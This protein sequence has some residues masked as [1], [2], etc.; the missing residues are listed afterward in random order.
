MQMWQQPVKTL[1]VKALESSKLT[2]G[3]L[4]FTDQSINQ[5]LALLSSKDGKLATLDLS[6]ASDRVHKDP[7][8]RMLNVNPSLRD[9]V[10]ITRS[11]RAAVSKSEFVD[12]NKFASMG[13]ALCFPIESLY[14]YILCICARL[15]HKHLQPSIETIYKVTR[16]IYVYG[17]DIIV[18]SNEVDSII[19]WL[20][21][22]GNKVGLAKSFW[23]GRFRE[24]CGCDAYDGVDITPIYIRQPLHGKWKSNHIAS[25]V[26]T[27]NLF[28]KKGL[29]S[30]ANLLRQMV[31]REVGRLPY[32]SEHSE[33]LGWTFCDEQVKTRYN[34]G[35][36]RLE[37]RTLVPKASKKSDALR[38]YS[39]L[40]KCLLKL[41][42]RLESVGR[43]GE[44]SPIPD[45]TSERSSFDDAM[46]DDKEHL[47]TV[48][49]F[50]ALTLKRQWVSV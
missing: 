44:D 14:F 21:I 16:D 50:G 38:N 29:C 40:S 15:E 30:S 7:V 27:A 18:P 8:Y 43:K 4:N 10:F 41:E 17:D 22:F 36:Q 19:T 25:F 1:M 48:P 42:H 24:S 2:K 35:L 45:W 5:N 12:L 9:L 23:D 34:K 28:W 6:E 20:H 31:E 3:H 47:E 49:R 39:A 13:S 33:G 11:K 37:V 26:A 46:F 32:R